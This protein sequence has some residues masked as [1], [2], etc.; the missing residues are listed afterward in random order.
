M[1]DSIASGLVTLVERRITEAMARGEFD[2]LPGQGKPLD[3]DDGPLVAEDLRVAMRILKNAGF[4]P[5]EVEQ[6][7]QLAQLLA[8]VE[9]DAQDAG[10]AAGRRVRALLMQLEAR[11]LHATAAR[12][13]TD[14][15]AALARRLDRTPRDA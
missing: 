3:L 5:P 4:V 14:Y 8:A 9:R 2:H 1:A 15:E 10:P 7:A 11:G 12:G 6:F 13:W